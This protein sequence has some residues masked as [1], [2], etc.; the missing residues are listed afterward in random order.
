M[1]SYWEVSEPKDDPNIAEEPSLYKFSKW[2]FLQFYQASL[3]DSQ[4]WLLLRRWK[5]LLIQMEVMQGLMT[6]PGHDCN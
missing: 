1:T 4:E 3:A 6:Q 2:E 5:S